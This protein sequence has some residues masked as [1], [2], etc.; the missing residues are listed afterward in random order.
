MRSVVK[1][2]ATAGRPRR[3]Q[4]PTPSV[5]AVQAAAKALFATTE[6]RVTR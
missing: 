3:L 4:S 2:A 6:C 5:N 1:S